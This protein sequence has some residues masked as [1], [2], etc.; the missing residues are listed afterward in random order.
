MPAN[1]KFSLRFIRSDAAFGTGK[2]DDI[3]TIKPTEGG[4]YTLDYLYRHAGRRIRTTQTRTGSDLFRWMRT[5]L[6]LLELDSAP[7]ATLQLDVT[8]FPSI[9]VEVATLFANSSRAY[10]A[11]LDTLELFLYMS[12]AEPAEPAALS[13]TKFEGFLQRREA[14]APDDYFT[15]QATEGDAFALKY[16]FSKGDEDE[17]T[18]ELLLN[19]DNTERWLRT[20]VD[21]LDLDNDP[22]AD[23]QLSVSG[24]P[25][26]LLS[27]GDVKGDRVYHRIGNAAARIEDTLEYFL[28]TIERPAAPA[29]EEEDFIPVPRGVTALVDEEDDLST[30]AYSTDSEEEYMDMPPLLPADQCCASH[31][32]NLRSRHLFF[33]E[34]GDVVMAY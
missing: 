7:F 26:I 21:L 9:L 10:H 27:V 17:Q 1:M 5:T 28:D 33:D 2:A 20:L 4:Q 29:A 8:G 30:E 15:I 16:V 19:R 3:V 24:F 6:G 23:F 12:S 18:S 25:D 13:S 34:D 32:Y 31:S 11:L 14:G 22:F